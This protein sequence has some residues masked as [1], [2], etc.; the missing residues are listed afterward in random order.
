MSKRRSLN[1]ILEVLIIS[2]TIFGIGCKKE[3]APESSSSTTKAVATDTGDVVAAAIV[4]GEIILKSD[5][6]AVVSMYSGGGE[7]GPMGGAHGDKQMD[8]ERIKQLRKKMLD[9]MIDGEILYQASKEYPIEG[10][11]EKAEEEY[12]NILK[13]YGSEEDFLIEAEKNNLTIEKI[14]MNL[15]KNITIQSYLDNEVI[16]KIEIK[17]DEMK[18]FYE[19]NKKQYEADE[20]VKAS[21]ILIKV[22][23][24]ATQE[25]KDEAMKEVAKVQERL[26]AG[27]DFADV[28][29][30]MSK[31]PSAPRGGDLGFFGRNQMVKP[32]ET[33]AF[34]LN[35]GEVSDLVETQYGYHI[36]KVYEKKA[37]QAKSYDEVK[38]EIEESLKRQGFQ[39]SI[40]KLIDDLK[41][42]ATIEI[43][44]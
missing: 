17:E 24:G 37:A 8:E 13:Q 20:Q 15:K 22:E 36:I 23:E 2:L 29:K 34:A 16:A 18:S 25:Q 14:K 10:V 27:E 5:L 35:A 30:E 41:A 3:V 7:G 4:N 26:K 43:H 6:D 40:T 19:A 28:A 1:L 42:K 12:A 39:A 33:A 31:G 38:P 32:F 44:D 21:H 11:D 9:Q